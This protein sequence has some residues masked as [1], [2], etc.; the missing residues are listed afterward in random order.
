MVAYSLLS[1]HTL[2]SCSVLLFYDSVCIGFLFFF[3][4]GFDGLA[5]V[6]CP[7]ML[8]CCCVSVG[9]VTV[10]DVYMR[11]VC[12]CTCPQ[13]LVLSVCTII[14]T[15]INSIVVYYAVF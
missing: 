10:V 5:P 13:S 7:V 8:C 3:G 9:K 14:I 15:V 6:R 12:M 4:V 11:S 1:L 2:L